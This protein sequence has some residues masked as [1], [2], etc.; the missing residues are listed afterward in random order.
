MLCFLLCELIE[1]WRVYAVSSRLRLDD[2]PE[3][4]NGLARRWQNGKWRKGSRR[5][6]KGERSWSKGVLRRQPYQ[7]L[8]IFG[9][10]IHRRWNQ[11]ILSMSFGLP[12]LTWPH[13]CELVLEWESGGE[14][15]EGQP[16][17]GD[18][19]ATNV[20]FDFILFY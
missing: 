8:M 13:F 5:W 15:V 19:E 18:R 6:W 9:F 12:K 20:W 4:T 1:E 17:G 2:K 7:T 3:W 14:V 10:M 11:G 16:G